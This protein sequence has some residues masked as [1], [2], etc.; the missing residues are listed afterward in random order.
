[1]KIFILTVLMIIVFLILISAKQIIPDEIETS[2]FTRP[3]YKIAVLFYRLINYKNNNEKQNFIRNEYLNKIYE[4]KRKLNPAG[5]TEDEV[6]SFYV[7]KMGM[8]IL[9]IFVGFIFVI[10]VDYKSNKNSII[11]GDNSI[12]RSSYGKINDTYELDASIESNNCE[13]N[14]EGMEI[15]VESSWY[16][17]SE[18]DE[19]LPL[20]LV[21]LE[22]EFLGKNESLDRITE[23]VNLVETIGDYPFSIEYEW[24]NHEI[25]NYKGEITDDE[26]KISENGELLEI[27]A[28]Y[29]YRDYEGD[30]IF[31]IMVY[32]KEYS[33]TEYLKKCINEKIS[34]INKLDNKKFYLP[35]EINGMKIT[36]SEKKKNNTVIFIVLILVAAVAIF[37][38]QDNDLYKEINKRNDELNEDYPEIVSKITLLL[39]AGL[40]ASGAFRKIALDY[41]KLK[42]NGE[43]E[44]RYA[45]EEM[46]Y[47]CYEMDNGIDEITCYQRFSSRCKLQKYIKLSALLEQTVKMG[48]KELISTLNHETK[49][50]FMEKRNNAEKKGEEAGTKL[51]VPMIMMLVIVMVII[52]YPALGSM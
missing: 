27:T 16:T 1:M 33:E 20:F 22:K 10:L 40:T 4:A 21:D 37:W 12:E 46:L 41:K 32:P 13:N 45:Y 31:N 39:G 38:G 19:I 35:G 14:I 34:E 44:V 30:Y 42:E 24:D 49:D 47:S 11:S 9:L 2:F 7:K 48:S 52:M 25:I 36:W 26:E 3:F 15:E 28:N 29:K 8:I 17:N 43:I 51:L 6:K 23:S 50:A 18:L 5:K